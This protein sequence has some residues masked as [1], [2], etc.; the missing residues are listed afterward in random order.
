MV[1]TKS[2]IRKY[3]IKRMVSEMNNPHFRLDPEIAKFM[4]EHDCS[5]TEAANTLELNYDEI[6]ITVDDE[7]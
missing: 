1:N 4:S 3:I 5:E 2:K 6:W 7:E